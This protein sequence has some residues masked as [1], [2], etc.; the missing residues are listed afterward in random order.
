MAYL[1]NMRMGGGA[2]VMPVTRRVTTVALSPPR[3]I[4]RKHGRAR[5]SQANISWEKSMH[6]STQLSD[7]RLRSAREI[8]RRPV[9][10]LHGRAIV[11]PYAR[12]GAPGRENEA[13]A[14]TRSI[15]AV[16]AFSHF[17]TEAVPNL[18]LAIVSLMITEAMAGCAA[19]A[20]A[21]YGIPLAAGE[22]QPEEMPARPG[23]SLT[24]VHTKDDFAR[25]APQAKSGSL[26][27]LPART[28]APIVV[29]PDE[30]RSGRRPWYVSVGAFIKA[31]RS[32]FR[33]AREQ[34][35]MIAELRGLD[36]RSRRDIGLSEADIEYMAWRGDWR[37]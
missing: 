26:A 22:S 31:C 36:E 34:R 21:M 12:E 6:T 9:H 3:G 35:R 33:K 23:V 8:A 1:A 37:E 19:Y 29:Q 24:L 18:V 20:E 15:K 32:R 27:G 7:R 17:A 13:N 30:R 11:I 16:S 10:D 28:A 4:F 2:C 5:N 14:W 25:H